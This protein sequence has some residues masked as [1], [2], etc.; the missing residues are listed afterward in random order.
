VLLAFLFSLL[1]QLSVFSQQHKAFCF[2]R[3]WTSPALEER[4]WR[5]R[6]QVPEDLDSL[7]CFLL[8]RLNSR[9]LMCVLK[10]LILSF[11]SAKFGT[12]LLCFLHCSCPP[13]KKKIASFSCPWRRFC[14]L[15]IWGIRCSWSVGPQ[16]AF[17]AK[18]WFSDNERYVS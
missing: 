1:L 6:S 7:F 15:W 18:L 11:S 17:G 2:R 3:L 9:N 5:T 16:T 8:D 4:F 12:S 13:G 14:K 10:T